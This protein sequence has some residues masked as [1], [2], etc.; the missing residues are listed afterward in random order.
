MRFLFDL[1]SPIM[2]I[3]SRFCDIVI[4]NIVFLLTCI[5]IFTIGAA[6]TA[7]YDVVFRMDTDREGKLLATYFRSFRENFRQSTVLWLALLLFGLATYM[8]MTRFSILGNNAYLLGYG[9]FI[10]SM[11]VLVL[12]VFLFSYSFP[13]LSLFRNSTRQ[14]AMNALLLAIGNLPRTLVVA[15]INCFPWVLLMVNF[16]AF[17][18]L[19][20]I[21]LAMYFAAAAYFNSRVLMKVFGKLIP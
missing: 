19:G 16:Y 14:T 8:N 7:L 6:N 10:V 17:M 4:L 11:L 13:L 1:D 15:V 21:W 18:Q 20:F 9:L 2:Q 3:I 5:P 12:E